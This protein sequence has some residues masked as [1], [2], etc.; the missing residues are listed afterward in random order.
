MKAHL[1]RLIILLLI[2]TMIAQTVVLAADEDTKNKKKLFKI[3]VYKDYIYVKDLDKDYERKYYSS[4][5]HD[6]DHNN[7]GFKVLF[8]YVNEINK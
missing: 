2:L 5:M 7:G 1:K 6:D 8:C 4:F 3:N